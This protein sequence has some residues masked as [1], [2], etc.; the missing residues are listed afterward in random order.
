[1]ARQGLINM[2]YIQVVSIVDADNVEELR[3]MA[4]DSGIEGATGLWSIPL[5]EESANPETD[6]PVAYMC[7]GWMHNDLIDLLPESIVEYA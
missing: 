1:M 6:Q 5:W 3:Q 7:A 2:N 4:A